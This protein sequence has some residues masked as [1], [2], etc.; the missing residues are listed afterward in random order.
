MHHKKLLIHLIIGYI[1]FISFE[2]HFNTTCVYFKML[3]KFSFL[4]VTR[5]DRGG[6]SFSFNIILIRETEQKQINACLLFYDKK[7]SRVLQT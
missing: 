6:F 2:K 3:H 1:T 5:K 4:C 7:Q